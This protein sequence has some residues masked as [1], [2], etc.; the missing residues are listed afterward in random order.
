MDGTRWD[1]MD[2]Q[3]RELFRSSSDGGLD[4][5][6]EP[7]ERRAGEEEFDGNGR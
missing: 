3:Q 7:I 4:G 2:R 5:D 1:E 6:G